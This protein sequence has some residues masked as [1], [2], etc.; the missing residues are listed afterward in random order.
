MNGYFSGLYDN[1]G[2]A[3]LVTGRPVSEWQTVDLPRADIDLYVN[4]SYVKSGKGAEAMG[5]PITS[6]TWMINWLRERKREILAGEIVSTG[7][8]TAH[9]FVARGDRVSVDFGELGLVEAVFS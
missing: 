8:C 4:D 6:L 2:G 7:T 5:H 3:A 9:C 1:G